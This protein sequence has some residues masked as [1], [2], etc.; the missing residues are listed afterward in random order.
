MK[1]RESCY[2][3]QYNTLTN[4]FCPF[5]WRFETVSKCSSSV[6]WELKA[7]YRVLAYLF[8]SWSW[9]TCIRLHCLYQLNPHLFVLAGGVWGSIGAKYLQQAV[10]QVQ[11]AMA[12]LIKPAFLRTPEQLLPLARWATAHLM[13]TMKNIMKQCLLTLQMNDTHWINGW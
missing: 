8:T 12:R 5:A 1:K 2:T 13:D 4:S 9:H 11:P 6:S 10:L 3:I 7:H